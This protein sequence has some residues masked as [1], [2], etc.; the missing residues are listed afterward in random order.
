M[1]FSS[2]TRRLENLYKK[3]QDQGLVVLGFPCNQFLG[4]E[5]LEGK[6]IEEFCQ[7]NYDVTFP[8]FEKLKV[9]GKEAHPLYTFLK[10]ETGGKSIKWNYTKFVINKN[11]EVIKRFSPR[12]APE[13]MTEDIESLL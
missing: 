3:Y 11:G 1:W 6:E 10:E 8:L 13:K 9:N 5:P 2:T 4:Q 12:T 7:L